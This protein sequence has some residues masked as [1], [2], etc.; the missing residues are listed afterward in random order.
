VSNTYKATSVLG[1]AHFG[2]PVFEAVFSPADEADWVDSG[3][4]E[5]VPR[6]YE[7]LSDNFSATKQGE[8]FDA[9]YRVEHEAALV[10]GG[11]IQRVDQSGAARG[12]KKTKA[13]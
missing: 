9:A 11:H 5:I 13:S 12:S 1:V 8:T 3:H 7:Q 10:S 2:E 6:K 4:V